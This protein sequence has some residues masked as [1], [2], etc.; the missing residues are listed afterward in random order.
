[1]LGLMQ[2]AF[3]TSLPDN[4]FTTCNKAVK[5]GWKDSCKGFSVADCRLVRVAANA[6]WESRCIEEIALFFPFGSFEPGRIARVISA[7]GGES[8]L[9]KIVLL[10]LRSS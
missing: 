10:Q 7:W 2:N 6:C 1:M 9:I 5:L 4:R 8:V 3:R